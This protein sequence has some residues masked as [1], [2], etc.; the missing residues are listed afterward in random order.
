[1]VGKQE[2]SGVESPANHAY[3]LQLPSLSGSSVLPQLHVTLSDIRRDEL[4]ATDSLNFRCPV[5]CFGQ[6]RCHHSNLRGLST[7]VQRD[8]LKCTVATTF[9]VVNPKICSVRTER[10]SRALS[11][12]RHFDAVKTHAQ[13]TSLSESLTS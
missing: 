3:Q 8:T 7:H 12:P 11:A 4:R 2:C 5:S 10:P 13:C 9:T 6:F 1:M